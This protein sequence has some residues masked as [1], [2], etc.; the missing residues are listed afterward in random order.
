M[1]RKDSLRPAL[2]ALL[3]DTLLAK[4]QLVQDGVL[5][6]N[7]KVIPNASQTALVEKMKGPEDEEI[8]KI[9]VAARAEMG[10]ANAELCRY[11]STIFK[12]P[13]GNVKIVFGDNIPRKLL[14][15]I[16]CADNAG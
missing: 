11:L 14:K 2:K 7:I 10:K 16:G 5:Y 15:I 9:K 3:M 4:Q 6:L 8:W 12:V 1:A 13:K